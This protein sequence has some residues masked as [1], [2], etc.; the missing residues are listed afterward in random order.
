MGE[1]WSRRRALLQFGG[2]VAASGAVAAGAALPITAAAQEH[3]GWN[4]QPPPAP[5]EAPPDFLGFDLGASTPRVFPAGQIRLLTQSQMPALDGLALFEVEFEQ[6]GLGELHWHANAHEMG[7]QIAGE[8]EVGILAPDGTGTITPIA[9]GSVTYIPHGY[10]HFFRN[11]GDGPMHRI[12][13]FTN[14]A[15]ETY[16]LSATLPPVPQT[17]LAATFGLA[18]ADFPYLPERGTQFIVNVPG[19]SPTPLAPEPNPYT[20][21]QATDMEPATYAGGTI[22]QISANEIPT[23]EAMTA[24]FLEIEAHGLREPHWHTNAREIDYCLSGQAEYGIVA[25]DGSHQ[26]FVLG[27]GGAAFI[28]ANWFHYIA[29]VGDE[30]LEILAF[31]DDPAPDH[32][33]L[34]R[35]FGFF[36]PE[37]IAA[38]FG[39]DPELISALPNEGDGVIAPAP[40]GFE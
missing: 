12:A 23:L 32:I 1:R 29:N 19:P 2:A 25:P 4:N 22:R 16:L 10:F 14:A 28:P 34:S 31:F 24:S 15:P 18:A 3:A 39:L 35:G 26:S 33:D 21:F 9:P 6:G 7:L 13:A 37:V 40:P 30:P 36:P 20:T 8:G 5:G 11:V 27:A 17:W 38:S